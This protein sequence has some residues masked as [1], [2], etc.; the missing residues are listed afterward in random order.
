MDELL[1]T[2]ELPSPLRLPG[3]SRDGTRGDDQ[4]VRR[5]L[6]PGGRPAVVELEH[7]G[8]AIR[9]RARAEDEQT[10]AAAIERARFWS[11][12]DEDLTPFLEQFAGDPLIGPSVR[13]APWLRPYRRPLPFEVLA[14]AIC[15]Q[16]ITDER[17]TEIKRALTFHHG[18]RHE[19][20]RDFPGPATLA[21]LAP[22]QLQRCGL[23]AA[24]ATT[25]IRASRDVAAGRV[26]LLDPAEREAGW[27]RLRTF[28][29]IGP[30]TL[31]TLALHGQGHADALPSGD[32]AYLTLVGEVLTGR[33]GAKADEGDV[34]EF[35]TP[36]AGWRGIAGWHLLRTG[37][38]AI[39]RA[40]ATDPT[41]RIH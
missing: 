32:H 23:T 21:G 6:H 39:R 22:A 5:L 20:L 36:Y 25:L 13:S 14:G 4:H 10:A 12:L 8:A 24:R 34:L 27:R 18:P 2:C 17:A 38:A 15:E 40:R 19:D 35:F 16:L 7:L 28:P 1:V 26:D 30:W 37:A 9:I 33:P 31:N 3:R 29:G 41:R 11:W